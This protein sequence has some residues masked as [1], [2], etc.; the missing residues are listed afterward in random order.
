[1]R[2]FRW[3]TAVFVGIIMVSALAVFGVSLNTRLTVLNRETWKQTS[4]QIYDLQRLNSLLQEIG[5]EL[6]PDMRDEQLRELEELRSTLA[7][8]ML[9]VSRVL[10]PSIDRYISNAVDGVWDYLIGSSEVI[11]LGPVSYSQVLESSLEQLH[12]QVRA[13]REGSEEPQ[14]ETVAFL[15]ELPADEFNQVLT[16]VGEL[17]RAGF[18]F[19]EPLAEANTKQ[20]YQPTAEDKA[21]RRQFHEIASATKT[22]TAVS[23]LVVLLCVTAFLLLG[24]KTK[25]RLRLN[26]NA[27]LWYSI[28]SALLFAGIALFPESFVRTVQGL[29]ASEATNRQA[30]EQVADT[31]R[32][33]LAEYGDILL[34][35]F[36]PLAVFVATTL[37]AGL[38]LRI[39]GRRKRAATKLG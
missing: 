6:S 36:V 28:P 13:V 15:A 37:A 9:S 31:A 21:F 12:S 14:S 27:L 20:V 1:M 18:L 26:G 7:Q 29:A 39:T 10:Q 30:N 3:I 25:S 33:V 24:A 5:P 8:E 23:A 32:V 2:V 4:T 34:N 16:R 17:Y 11:D 19:I 38:L 22:V 35:F